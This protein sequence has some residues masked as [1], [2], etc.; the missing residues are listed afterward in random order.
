MIESK[1]NAELRARIVEYVRANPG[2][3]NKDIREAMGIDV[4]TLS[5]AFVILVRDKRIHRAGAIQRW[6][7]YGSAELAAQA[8]P[9]I[10]AELAQ[11]AADRIAKRR[12]DQLRQRAERKA[13]RQPIK[14]HSWVKEKILAYIRGNEGCK[15]PEI[16]AETGIAKGTFDNGLR[17]LMQAGEVIAI[18]P[19][20]VRRYF[21]DAARAAAA[22]ETL[23]D[24]M[25]ELS[26]DRAMRVAKRNAEAHAESLARNSAERLAARER[27]LQQRIRQ[28]AQR[29]AEEQAAAKARAEER[30][31]AAERKA[32]ER[33]EREREEQQRK[34]ARLREQAQK[35]AEK[36]AAEAKAREERMLVRL[37]PRQSVHVPSAAE[38][39]RAA[40]AIVPAGVRVT[41][42]PPAQLDRWAVSIDPGRGAISRDA[43]ARR[44]GAQIPSR[45]NGAY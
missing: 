15:G 35:R 1:N 22:A 43:E 4:V 45:L 5:N 33:A 10:D 44:H 7:Y 23:G 24:L 25:A 28:R 36:A 31:R 42:C 37:A 41:I 2:A 40:E 11:H 26:A 27:A 9:V 6:H 18:G 30:Q 39:W 38:R 14:L 16:K 20:G 32:A 19:A 8:Q 21:T 13:G 3:Q 29:L 34:M 12:R 17:R